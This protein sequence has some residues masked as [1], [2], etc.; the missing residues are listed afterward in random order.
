[1]NIE[2]HI[3]R[4]VL[5]GIDIPRGHGEQLRAGVSAEL[6]RLLRDGGL[7]DTVVHGGAVARVRAPSARLSASGPDQLG[8][9]LAGAIYDGIGEPR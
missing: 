8:R 2:L 5:D 9:Q 1:M 3:D 4:L 6:A 7:A